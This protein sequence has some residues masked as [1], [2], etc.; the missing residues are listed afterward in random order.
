MSINKKNIIYDFH[1]GNIEKMFQ[2]IYI[3]INKRAKIDD[4]FL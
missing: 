3:Y 4:R 2:D 1:L